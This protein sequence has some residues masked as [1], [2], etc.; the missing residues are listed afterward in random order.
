MKHNRKTTLSLG[1][2]AALAVGVATV[3]PVY[4]AGNRGEAAGQFKQG[5]MMGGQAGQFEHGGNMGNQGARYDHGG[6]MGNKGGQFGHGGNMGS[7]GGQFDHGGDM[8]GQGDMMQKMMQMH[9]QMNGG[10]GGMMGGGQMGGIG[11]MQ[12][13]DA[14][15]DGAVTPEEARAGLQGLLEEFDT[16]SDGTLS[17]G[18]FEALYGATIREKMV[19]GFQMLDND[20]DGQVTADEIT[21]PVER[22]DDMMKFKTGKRG[23]GGTFG[24]NGM[25]ADSETMMQNQGN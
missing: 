20:G 18:E 10:Q 8:A 21:A 17:I 14:N 24:G 16:N 2:V 3:S 25:G 23:S 22:M 1:L 9:G 12:D 4:A 19:D 5:G 11:F 6:N 7:Q 15:G 13:L